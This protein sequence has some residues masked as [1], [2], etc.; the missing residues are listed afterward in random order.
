MKKHFTILVTDD[1]ISVRNTVHSMLNEDTE[2]TYSVLMATNG[3]EACTTAYHERPDLI[4]LDIEMPVM[5]G[6][7]AIKKI[8]ENN[9][10]KRIPIVLMSSTKQFQEA[11]LAGAD[12]FLI[13][14]FNTYELLLRIQLNLKLARKGIE[15]KKQHELLKIQKQ[16]AINQRDI[17]YQQKNDLMDDLHYAR[18]VQN[19]ILPSAK[20]FNELIG[21]HFIYDRPKYI[22]SGDFYWVTQ[23]E[24]RTV[25]AVGDCTGHGMSGGLMTMAGAAFLNEIV[26]ATHQLRTDQILNDLRRKVIQLLN[27]KG[28]IGEAA[29]GMDISLC[30]YNK[31]NQTIQFSGANN[32]LYLVRKNEPLEIFKGDRM[33]IGFF[34]EHEQPFT[35][36]EIKVSKGDSIFMFTD[37]YPDQFGGSFEKKFRY[38]QFRDLLEKA[39]S[40]PTMEEQLELIQKTMNE[41]IEGY[42]QLDDML[43]LGIRF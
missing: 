6:I 9:L 28:N 17:I 1:S 38:N 33:P 23:K 8:K 40:C 20:D 36:K 26:N 16:E 7:E 34:F 42:E 35:E 2:N 19:A 24:E 27:Q 4:L 22:V 12:D 18:Y 21:N 31:E 10:I 25:I 37:G 5:N 14:P 30:I 43:I 3:R 41:W 32:P 29:N 15:I 11:F 39:A 13:K